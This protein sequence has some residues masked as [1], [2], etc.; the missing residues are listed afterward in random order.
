ML[1]KGSAETSI[2]WKDF[3]VVLILLS[4]AFSWYYM[5][6]IML[7]SVLGRLN[8]AYPQDFILWTVYY[9]AIVGSGVVGSIL[10]SKVDRLNFLY[11][12]MLLGVV[13]SLSPALLN[14][15][16]MIHAL[17]VDILLGISFGL[18]MPS[19]LAYFADCT[20]VEN[21]GKISGIIFL[22]TNLSAPLFVISL[23]VF[24]HLM[25]NSIIF[26]A[27][28]GLGLILFFLLKPQEKIAA[29]TKKSLSFGSILDNKS[30]VLYL[31]AWLMFRL[32]DRFEEPVLMNFLDPSFFRFMFMTE[33]ILAS[34]SAL[35]GGLLSDLIGR[36]RV[37]IYGFV[38]LGLAYAIIGVAPMITI[39]WYF[40]LVVD[41][42]AAGILWVIFIL[43][44]WG[45]LSPVGSREKYYVIGSIPFFISDVIP[46]FLTHYVTM[47]SAYAAFSLA[48]FFL[49]LA[50]LPLLYAPETLP[51]KKIELRKLRKY[52]EEAKKA[53]QK[54]TGEVC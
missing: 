6:H 7:N 23:R 37:I 9:V 3:L 47:I 11:F 26:A 51:E 27:W 19:C 39:S 44:L 41:G 48:S 34:L 54:Y 25:L 22:I 12:W 45:D 43:I 13:T 42:I 15:I 31:A 16:T 4:N 46:L 24:D 49:F 40:Y 1:K 50:V 2:A 52:V 30:F 38:A 17:I 14:N 53:Q 32:V 36:K 8:V 10:S 21:R 33:P 5:T 35:V 29:G 20:L 18:G 28:R